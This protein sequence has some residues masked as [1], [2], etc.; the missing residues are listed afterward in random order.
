MSIPV[1]EQDIIKTIKEFG[2]SAYL[3]STSEDGHPHL[4]NLKFDI[5]ET[6]LIFTVGRRG[7]SNLEKSPLVTMLWPA[8]EVGGYSLIID[9][10]AS[11]HKNVD[12]NDSV[13]K[14]SFNTGILH[15]PAE[16]ES[17]NSDPSCG[18]DCQAI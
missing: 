8:K 6:D 13:W 14:I 1:E 17:T 3:I 5:Y 12:L 10:N 7:T 11:K 18:S 9:G 15:R 16:Q 4:A 2:S